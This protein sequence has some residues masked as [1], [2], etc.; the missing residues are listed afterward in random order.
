ANRGDDWCIIS[1]RQ[2]GIEPALNAVWP[3]AGRRYCCKHLAKNWKGE[4]SGP[5]MHSLFWRAASAT[6]PFTFRKAMERIEKENP[7]ARIWLAN[8]GDQSRWTRHKFDPKICS[9]KNKS[10]FVE[11]FNATL[12]I[13]RCRP[14]LILLE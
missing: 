13:D 8:L 2:K 11:S 12:G 1:D 10:N 5:L 14:V 3:K 7:L 9:E 4:F 6:S